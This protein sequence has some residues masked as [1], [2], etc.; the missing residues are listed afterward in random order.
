MKELDYPRLFALRQETA[1]RNPNEHSGLGGII[2]DIFKTK[3]PETP[4]QGDIEVK[5]IRPVDLKDYT[6]ILGWFS[7]PETRGHLDIFPDLPTDWNDPEQIKKAMFRLHEYYLNFGDDPKKIA[8]LA[9]VDQRDEIV[10][11]E[12]I[13]WR[14]DPFIP[15]GSKIKIAGIER[16][17]VDPEVRRKSAGS[18]LVKESLRMAFVDGGYDEVRAW[19]YS[20]EQAGDWNI[21]F[22]FFRKLG[23]D[24]YGGTHK[25]WREYAE[26]R[27]MGENE[28]NRDAIWLSIK[29]KTWEA[30]K[31]VSQLELMDQPANNQK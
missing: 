18:K 14:G 4:E 17:I 30:K 15:K 31:P 22:Q 21:N 3:K 24:I 26:A 11:V 9:A 2:R 1:G 7:D 23:F 5:T 20:D 8:A 28:Q 6:R 27:G 12:T 13:R 29:R 25:T 19:V 16:L 10:G